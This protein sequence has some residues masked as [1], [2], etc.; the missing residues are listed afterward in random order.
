M[1]RCVRVQPHYFKF[2]GLAHVSLT[3]FQVL[4]LQICERFLNEGEATGLRNFFDAHL[5]SDWSV[6]WVRR[7][8]SPRSCVLPSLLLLCRSPYEYGEKVVAGERLS[9]TLQRIDWGEEVTVQSSFGCFI[10]ALRAAS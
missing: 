3:L 4:G 6:E 8:P 1:Q 2:V 10:V 7:L 9:S 5:A